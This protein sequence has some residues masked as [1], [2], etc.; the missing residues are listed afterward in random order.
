MLAHGDRSAQTCAF[1][2]LGIASDVDRAF[3]HVDVCA[4]D[5]RT[6]FDEELRGVADETAAVAEQTGRASGGEE[7]EIAADGLVVE[8]E[9]IP[10]VAE[11]EGSSVIFGFR[12]RVAVASACDCL[13]VEGEGFPIF[14]ARM[15]ST[16]LLSGV[17]VAGDEQVVSVSGF[18]HR[19]FHRQVVLSRI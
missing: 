13:S 11:A 19:I 17:E 5:C 7:F 14:S 15:A 3:R 9:D 4:F 1:H 16:S 18:D 6:L 10:D 8:H 2:H 12:G